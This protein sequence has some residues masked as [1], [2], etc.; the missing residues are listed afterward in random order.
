MIRHC[1]D[2]LLD[3]SE[4]DRRAFFTEADI[5]SELIFNPVVSAL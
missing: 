4:L 2:K 5:I 1:S 3:W